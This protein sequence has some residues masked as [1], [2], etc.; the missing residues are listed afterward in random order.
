M[1][2][3]LVYSLKN[4]ILET[5]Y[6]F[7][8]VSP[9]SAAVSKSVYVLYHDVSEVFL[10]FSVKMDLKQQCSLLKYCGIKKIS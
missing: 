9:A 8:T 3:I 6:L 5:E 7:F 10:T 4:K 2:N 1:I